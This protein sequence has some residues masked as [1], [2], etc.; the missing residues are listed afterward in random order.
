MGVNGIDGISVSPPPLQSSSANHAAQ[1]AS[2]TVQTSQAKVVSQP[3]KSA[4]TSG[5]NLENERRDS[6]ESLKVAVEKTQKFVNLKASDIQFS[7][8]EDSNK[9]IVKV[10]DR[11]TKDVIRQIPS[12]EML[13]IAEAL[14]KLQGL[15]VKEQA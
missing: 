1:P 11:T 9:M 6:F 8:D 2:G 5:S 12:K 4:D 7:L 3:E 15:L 10:I 14:E 13:D